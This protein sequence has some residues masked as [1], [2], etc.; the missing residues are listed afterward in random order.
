MMLHLIKDLQRDSFKDR[1][2]IIHGFSMGA[3]C[4]GLFLRNI[5]ATDEGLNQYGDVAVRIK[6][7]YVYVL[8]F[9]LDYR[10]ARKY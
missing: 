2:I 4:Y 7:I 3:Y 9:E 8:H 5:L 6:G 1:D 10:N